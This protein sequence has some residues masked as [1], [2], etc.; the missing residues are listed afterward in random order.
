MWA[1]VRDAVDLGENF[2]SVRTR[3][4]A[5]AVGCSTSTVRRSIKVLVE[6]KFLIAIQ[7]RGTYKFPVYKIGKER[8]PRIPLPNLLGRGQGE[9]LKNCTKNPHPNPLPAPQG[10]GIEAPI[11]HTGMTASV[12]TD[13][14][15]PY[16]TKLP[17]ENV[18]R[19]VREHN[20]PRFDEIGPRSFIDEEHDMIAR[21]ALTALPK[22]N[23]DA[24]INEAV[25]KAGQYLGLSV[26]EVRANHVAFIFVKQIYSR[27][28]A[29]QMRAWQVRQKIAQPLPPAITEEEMNMIHMSN[30]DKIMIPR[31][32]I[33]KFVRNAYY[34]TYKNYGLTTLEV[35]SNVEYR[36]LHQIE[37][38]RLKAAYEKEIMAAEAERTPS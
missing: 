33:G 31:H 6:Q 27:M 18:L 29:V 20:P 8:K 19:A 17:S 24:C 9:G 34:N 36:N 3:K 2:R 30:C 11:S 35:Q 23:T 28:I 22:E 26:D 21:M 10:E 15:R 38:Y 16:F 14:L 37:F 13:S 4:V 12:M 32:E 1:Q 5:E 7:Y 25:E